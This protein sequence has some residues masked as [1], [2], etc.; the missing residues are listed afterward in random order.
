MLLLWLWP[1]LWDRE[2]NWFTVPEPPYDTLHDAIGIR[3]KDKGSLIDFGIKYKQVELTSDGTIDFE[4]LG[5]VITK[6]TQMVAI[7][8]A[9]GYAFRPAIMLE[10]IK[11]CVDFVKGINPD[12]VMTA[13]NCYGKF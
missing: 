6:D 4:A 13:D 11:K 8:R 10:E 2:K 9:T 1:E 3:G 12:I 7:Q 5:K